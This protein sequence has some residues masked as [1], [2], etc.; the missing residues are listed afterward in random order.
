M[1]SEQAMALGILKAFDHYPAGRRKGR[2]GRR[3]KM[4]TV[5]FRRTGFG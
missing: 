2:E 5:A 3:N 4:F 1:E